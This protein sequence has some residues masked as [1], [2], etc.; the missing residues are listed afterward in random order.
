MNAC[1]HVCMYT[2]QSANNESVC[3]RS[4]PKQVLPTYLCKVVT[5]NAYLC[6]PYV[7]I[8]SRIVYLSELIPRLGH[9]IDFFLTSFRF[10]VSGSSNAAH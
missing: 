3:G 6:Y 4:E 8:T 1:M 9:L 10:I 2:V 5:P 7:A